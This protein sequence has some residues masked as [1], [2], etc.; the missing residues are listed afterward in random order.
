M[1]DS[2]ICA[3]IRTESDTT[4][5]TDV[6]QQADPTGGVCICGITCTGANIQCIQVTTS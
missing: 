3:V 4:T 5:T 6:V 2:Y 1:S